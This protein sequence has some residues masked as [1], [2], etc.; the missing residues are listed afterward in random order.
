MDFHSWKSGTPCD[1]HDFQWCA[2]CKPDDPTK[3]V[4]PKPDDKA[5]G[6]TRRMASSARGRSD[7]PR[8]GAGTR[9]LWSDQELDVLVAIFFS[10]EFA[11]GDDQRP[12]NHAMSVAMD[13][14]PA[15]IDRQWRNIA[16]L[17]KG[18]QTLHIGLNVQA[19][20]D[21]YLADPGGAKAKAKA[22]IKRNSWD[23]AWLL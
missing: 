20:L 23:L 3:P 6:L 1:L 9:R 8:P 16:D 13:R 7:R 10:V 2:A 15:A 21:R 19:A 22:T 11:A 12:E 14:T 17:Q 4:A 5:G 18:V